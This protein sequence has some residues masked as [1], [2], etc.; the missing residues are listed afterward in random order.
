[1]AGC[2]KLV[3][4]RA[5]EVAMAGLDRIARGVAAIWAGFV[6]GAG[7]LAHPNVTGT[8]SILVAGAIVLAVLSALYAVVAIDGGHPGAGGIALMIAACAPT[9]AAMPANLVPL[10]LGIAL[11]VRTVRREHA[12]P[13]AGSAQHGPLHRA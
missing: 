10:L 11:V 6:V 9:F 1:V 7:V 13:V 12:T 2:G 8:A 3:A 5:E 4:R